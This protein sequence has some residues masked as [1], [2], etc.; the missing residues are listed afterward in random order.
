MGLSL[1]VRRRPQRLTT[2]C[3]LLNMAVDATDPVE[4]LR[5]VATWFTA[6]LQ[7]VFQSWKKPFN[8]ILGETWQARRRTLGSLDQAVRQGLIAACKHFRG[9][10]GSGA[11][12]LASL[13]PLLGLSALDEQAY[14]RGAFVEC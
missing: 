13:A 11:D 3:R 14:N 7:H 10:Y 12:G 9:P 6:G 5:W 4:R 8:P 2:A 1:T